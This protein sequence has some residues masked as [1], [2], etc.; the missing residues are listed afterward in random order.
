M[1]KMLQFEVRPWITND[2]RGAKIGNIFYGS[3][4]YLVID[5]YSHYQI[6]LGSKE[7]Q[8]PSGQKGGDHYQNFIDAVRARDRSLL[9]AEIE[10]GHYSSALCHLGLVSARLGRSFQFDPINEQVIGDAEA[11]K[12]MTRDYREPFVVKPITA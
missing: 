10:E 6:Y 12:M 4:G 9:N 11:N 7:E 2:E 1:G 5:T 3:E 8:G